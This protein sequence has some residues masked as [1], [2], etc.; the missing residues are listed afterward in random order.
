MAELQ[1]YIFRAIQAFFLLIIAIAWLVGF[2]RQRN[3]G[4]LLLAIVF[5]AEGGDWNPTG[6]HQSCYLP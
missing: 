1:T 3:L 2:I 4:F 6:D 5:L